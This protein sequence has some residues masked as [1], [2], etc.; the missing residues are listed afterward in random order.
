MSKLQHDLANFVG[1]FQLS[2]PAHMFCAEKALERSRNLQ[3]LIGSSNCARSAKNPFKYDERKMMIENA[4]VERFGPNIMERIHFA[5]LPDF[6]YDIPTWQEHLQAVTH[7][8]ADKI[9]IKTNKENTVMVGSMKNSQ[10]SWLKWFP[11]YGELLLPPQDGFHATRLRKTYFESTRD[12]PVADMGLGICPTAYSFL[13]DWRKRD[14]H[15]SR[16]KREHFYIKSYKDSW[17][18]APFP[19]HLITTDAVVIKS[20]HI[21]LVRR[22]GDYGKS[23]LALPGGFLKVEKTLIENAISELTEET[24]IDQFISPNV[25]RGSIEAYHEFDDVERSSLG[26]CVT[27]AYLFRLRDTGEL[28]PLVGADDAEWAGWVPLSELDPEEFFED[29]WHIIQKMRGLEGRNR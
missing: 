11:Q 12:V 2:H 19:I 18:H 9:G 3:F 25:L 10:S 5:R 27:H 24:S 8:A 7:E 20:G 21:A 14:E 17:K 22:G 28:P 13:E 1:R 26:R 23:L 16:M 29:H 4:M 15:Y 6:P